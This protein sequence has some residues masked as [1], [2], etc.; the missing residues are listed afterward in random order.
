MLFGDKKW[1]VYFTFL[2]FSSYPGFIPTL[3]TFAAI[4]RNL[5]HNRA[6]GRSSNNDS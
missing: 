2:A 1:R 6:L 3:D 5:A 4:A